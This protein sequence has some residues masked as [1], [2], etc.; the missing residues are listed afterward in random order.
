MIV[1]KKIDLNKK[2]TKKQIKMLEEARNREDVYDPDCPPQTEE[3]LKQFVRVGN[4]KHVTIYLDNVVIDY[5]KNLS[6]ETDIPY[7]TLIN[8]YLRHC[9]DDKI[10]PDTKWKKTG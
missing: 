3:D 5:F 6:Q 4:K 9:A 1:T 7:Q 10:K 8:M 2:L